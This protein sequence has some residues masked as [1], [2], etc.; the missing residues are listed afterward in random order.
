M[1]EAPTPQQA[2]D[3]AAATTRQAH[4]AAALPTWGPAATGVFA[5]LFVTLL[6]VANVREF[7]DPI[8]WTLT[9]A[10]LAS[11]AVSFAIGRRMRRLRRARGLVPR[12]LAEWK[13]IVV[14]LAVLIVPGISLGNPTLTVGLQILC[15]LIMGG[16][17]WYDGARP[18]T[19]SWKFRRWIAR[20]GN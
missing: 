15:G 2:L 3:I 9:V 12:P 5:G 11:M 14:L 20:W 19:A 18:Q 7:D 10:A 16:W 8:A 4:E 13:F 17:I 6:G 1:Q